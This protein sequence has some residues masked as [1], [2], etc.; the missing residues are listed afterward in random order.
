MIFKK[1]ADNQQYMASWF[2]IICMFCLIEMGHSSEWVV[3]LYLLLHLSWVV[4]WINKKL[5][6]KRFMLLFSL[7]NLALIFLSTPFFEADFYRYFIDGLHALQGLPVYSFS[8]KNSPLAIEY[9][10]V[11]QNSQYNQYKSIYPGASVFYFKYLVWLSEKNIHSFVFL[12]K[13]SALL[14]GAIISLMLNHLKYSRLIPTNGLLILFHPLFILEWYINLHYDFLFALAILILVAIKNPYLKQIALALGFHLKFLILLFIP[15]SSLP[16]KHYLWSMLLLALG[17]WILYPSIG[18]LNAMF[19][20]ILVFGSQWEMNA[21]SFK[22]SRILFSQVFNQD[23]AIKLSY[24][25]QAIILVLGYLLV[26][27]KSR[28][29]DRRS[30]WLLIFLFIMTSP[31]VNPWYFSWI[32]PLAI[33]SPLKTSLK[34]IIFI[35]SLLNYMYYISDVFDAWAALEHISM[36]VLILKTIF[37]QQE[38][39]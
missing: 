21:G 38:T 15:F 32:L 33:L 36:F 3:F 29:L 16:K 8:P 35:P 17:G 11:W 14:F 18:E 1:L 19:R 23:M 20:N 37:S 25:A 28:K 39:H 9:L 7:A 10:E 5:L 4:L 34:Y 6:S 26:R 30:Y 24:L 12:L 13:I 2:S 27:A 31:V 22:L